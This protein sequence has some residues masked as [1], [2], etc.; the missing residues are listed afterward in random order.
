MKP[1]AAL[2]AVL[3]WGVLTMWAPERWVLSLYQAGALLLC[4]VYASTSKI[5]WH[6][7][8][9][10]LAV[11]PL[12]G[13]LQIAFGATI[14]GWE[15]SNSVLNW[16]TN[17]AVFFVALQFSADRRLRDF[18]LELLLYFGFALSILSTLQMFTSGGKIFWLFPS[19]YTDFIMGPFPNRN[20]Y[21][22]FIEI[23]LP[24]ALFRV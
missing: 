16:T 1:I 19:G 20:Q 17:L 5:H 11:P 9:A 2:A 24:L 22:A 15:T 4:A 8:L 10:C 3:F 13:L 7:L 23:I 21:A 14:Y 18:F 6:P 12:G